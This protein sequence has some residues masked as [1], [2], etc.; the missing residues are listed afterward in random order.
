LFERHASLSGLPSSQQRSLH[1]ATL[2]RRI[3]PCR[4]EWEKGKRAG[5]TQFGDRLKTQ[6]QPRS[7]DT[8]TSLLG[9]VH[10]L[11]WPPSARYSPQ[12]AATQQLAD[13][14]LQTPEGSHHLILCL[15]PSRHA[16]GAY[17]RPDYSPTGAGLPRP[18]RPKLPVTEDQVV[19]G[20]CT[21]NPRP[22]SA[23]HLLCGPASLALSLIW[24][25]PLTLTPCQPHPCLL[26]PH[27]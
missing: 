22:T 9:S 5:T 2:D 6:Q 7:T 15:R 10:P 13:C 26:P 19:T 4:T 27:P 14:I 17:S 21:V 1:R 8:C 11:V 3:A 23:P 16:L 18:L 25:V 12:T 20:C 24:S